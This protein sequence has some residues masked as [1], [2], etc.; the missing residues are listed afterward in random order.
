MQQ[1]SSILA[2]L[3][4]G[5]LSTV[6]ASIAAAA[7]AAPGG[8]AVSPRGPA[9]NGA[10]S[11]PWPQM[12]PAPAGAPNVIVILLDDVGFGAS[13]PFGGPAH[14]PY[15]D[16]LAAEG[17]RYNNF[18]TAAVSSPTRASLLTGRNHHQVGFGFVAEGGPDP[19][20]NFTWP[21]STA[22]IP[23]VLRRNGYSTA[24]F[25]KWHNTPNWELSPAGPFDRWPTGLGFEYFYGFQN[26]ETSQW[27]PLMV[28]NTLYVEPPA[29]PDQGYHLTTDITDDA[30]RWLHTHEAA[31]PQKPYFLYFAPGAT[32]APHHVPTEWIAKYRGKFDQGWDKLRE[33]TFTRQK[34][35]AV[36]PA[37][38]ELTPRPVELPAWDSLSADQKRLASRQMEVYAAFLEHTDHEVGRLLEAVRTG[39]NGD[40]TLVLYVLGDNGGSAEGGILGSDRN[41]AVMV[42]ASN[43]LSE[44]LKSIEEL[45]NEKWD[46]HY[47]VAWAWATNTPFQWTKLVAGHFGGSRNGMVVSWPQKLKGHGGEVRSQ[48]GHVNDIAATVYDATGIAL[49]DNVDGVKQLPLEGRS[50]RPTFTTAGAP[51]KSRTQY[52]EVL[53]NRGIYK[54]GWMASARHGVSWKMFANDN[55][56]GQDRWELYNVAEDF[57]QARDLADK[58]PRK[59]AELKHQFDR[60]AKRNGVLPIRNSVSPE[61]RRNFSPPKSFG[62]AKEFTYYPDQAPLP[63]LSLPSL[64]RAH[65]F[66]ARIEIPKDGAEGVVVALG[67]R[68]GGF[69]LFVKDSRLVFENNSFNIARDVLVSPDRLPEGS[70]EVAVVFIPADKGAASWGAGTVKMEINGAVVAEREL[71]RLATS[72]LNESLDVGKDLRSPVSNAYHAPY[73][74]TGKIQR[75]R[76]S[77]Q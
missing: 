40:N 22:S 53:G 28:R 60:E 72:E 30:I 59:L 71:A 8:K 48:F 67:G 35:Q 25:G 34:A 26:G 75:V 20:Y 64:M 70:L 15:L 66:A 69:S 77:L 13:S 62:Q 2:V 29:T 12:P 16:K 27:E 33:D 18:H 5:I 17:L 6:F 65:R 54:D 11:Q 76:L 49:P 68:A 58:H 3:I 41:L 21:K 24:G 63:Q 1:S 52:F 73:A 10:P 61:T 7:L 50:L 44:Q 14:T 56:F 39:P 57:S 32:H 19:G 51:T 36:I 4:R 31:A 74:F 55:N 23:D 38:A 46:N 42:G 43:P 37:N 45:G 9:A 47:S